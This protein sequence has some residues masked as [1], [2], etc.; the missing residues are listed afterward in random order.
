MLSILLIYCYIRRKT[1][2]IAQSSAGKSHL[3][4]MIMDEAKQMAILD[5]DAQEE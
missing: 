5:R 3:L 2:S 4:K 1:A